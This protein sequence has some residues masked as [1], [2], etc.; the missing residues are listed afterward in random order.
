MKTRRR[1]GG[2]AG[3]REVGRVRPGGSLDVEEEETEDDARVPGL[4]SE[5]TPA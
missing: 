2:T 5:G 1:T 4:T 3:G